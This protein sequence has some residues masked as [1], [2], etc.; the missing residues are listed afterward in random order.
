LKMSRSLRRVCVSV[1]CAL[2]GTGA[3][4]CSSYAPIGDGEDLLSTDL[5][6]GTH[7]RVHLLDGTAVRCTV[8]ELTGDELI[9]KTQGY[10]FESID[11]VERECGTIGGYL[12]FAVAAA[13]ALVITALAHWSFRLGG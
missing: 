13:G 10:P 12:L 5:S 8:V 4:S 7:V 11:Y 1:L 6:P 9:C 3:V 2:M